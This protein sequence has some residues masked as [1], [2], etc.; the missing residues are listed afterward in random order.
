M[1][2]NGRH[3]SRRSIIALGVVGVVLVAAVGA[4]LARGG[5]S[6]D[7]AA[8]GPSAGDATEVSDSTEAAP[9]TTERARPIPAAPDRPATSPDETSAPLPEPAPE[10]VTTQVVLDP[11][12]QAM[13]VP[14][15][16]VV[17]NGE[18][19]IRLLEIPTG[20]MRSIDTDIGRT[21][22]AMVVGDRAI[23]VSSYDDGALAIVDPDGTVSE[24]ELL[25]GAGQMLARPGTNDFLVAPNNWSGSEP[26]PNLVV[27]A[28]GSA[29]EVDGG[30][31]AEYDIW[32]IR[33]IPATGE[34]VVEDSGGAY[35]LDA[36]GA[37]RRITAGDLVAVGQ[38]HL[39]VREC[40]EAL[41]CIHFRIDAITGDRQL[42]VV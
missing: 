2:T 33:H 5:D 21:S 40:N 16:L 25:G 42:V 35:A 17:M 19:N 36:A 11:R 7:D 30:P 9:S 13:T 28:D 37:V 34:A 10:W 6:T 15:E 24:V 14:T 3:R 39:V 4:A 32:S 23:A 22:L 12:L 26:P 18:G 8:G 20:V 1:T 31:M 27:A 29:T 38:N 41:V